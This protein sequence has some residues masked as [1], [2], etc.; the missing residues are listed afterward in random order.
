M[1]E[2]NKLNVK[3]SLPY[4]RKQHLTIVPLKMEDVINHIKEKKYDEYTTEELIKKA[5]SYP[6]NALRN[7]CKNIEKHMGTITKQK[8][9]DLLA[10]KEAD[11]Q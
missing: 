10:D 8:R 4:K 9:D 11:E 1:N 2:F 5:L 3:L 6:Q 7:F